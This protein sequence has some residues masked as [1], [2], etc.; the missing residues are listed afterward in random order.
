MANNKKI[1]Q[2]EANAIF[3]EFLP[4]ITEMG[5]TFPNKVVWETLMANNF[6]KEKTVHALLQLPQEKPEK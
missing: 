2:E 4:F 5:L 3:K 6:E 1:T